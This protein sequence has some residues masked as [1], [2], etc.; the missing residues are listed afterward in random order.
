MA[1]DNTEPDD[2]YEELQQY[3][4]KAA[5]PYHSWDEVN[6]AMIRHWCD[7]MGDSNPAYTNAEF[8]D[9]SSHGGIVAPPT[10]LQA[11][12]MRN[13][14]GE[15]APGSSMEDS[16]KPVA[17]L[18]DAG[19][20]GVVAVNCEQEYFRYVTPGEK[21][22]YN[23]RIESVSEEKSTALGKGFFVTQLS[24]YFNQA[25]EKVAEMRFR[26]LKF[27]PQEIAPSKRDAVAEKPQAQRFHP[28]RHEDNT[29]FWEG[30][31]KGELHVQR[32]KSC[33]TLRHPPGPI[34]AQCHS[35]EWDT[36]VSTGRGTLYSFVVMHDPKIP[37]F[38]YPN[39]IGLIELEEGSRLIA[40]LVNIERDDI[41]IGMAL[42]V[43]FNEVEA[44]LIL[45]QFQAAK[46]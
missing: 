37:P 28:P 15:Q 45:P 44:G 8:A 7:A 31:D 33:Q 4:D 18:H 43:Q 12:C 42:E 32:C 35:M 24:E 25:D 27:L 46:A 34:C 26:I 23:A 21:L 5:G 6:Q 13:V 17:I 9:Q 19:Y 40:Q 30:I 10:M 36:V 1:A 14:H 39:I 16:M 11:W 2:L 29:F 20:K 3:V 41:E 38:T 22:Y